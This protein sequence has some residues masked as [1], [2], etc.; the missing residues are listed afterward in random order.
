MH[1]KISYFL[2]QSIA[3]KF[4]ICEKFK[5]TEINKNEKGDFIFLPGS[6]RNGFKCR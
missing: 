4:Y 5:L 3:L 6:D 1:F 2:L